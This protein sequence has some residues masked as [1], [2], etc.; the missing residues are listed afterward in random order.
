MATP[1]RKQVIRQRD[2]SA[3][4]I[5]EDAERR[6]DTKIFK[7]AL[8]SASNVRPLPTGALTRRPGRTILYF[9]GGLHDIVR[10]A[11]DAQFDVTFAA[12]RFTARTTTGAI[13]SDLVAPWTADILAEM[14]WEPIG[15]QIFV[16]HRDMVPQVLTYDRDAG[17]W[18]IADYDFATGLSG[19][20]KAAFYRFGDAG[21]T[22]QPSALSGT[23]TLTASA[24]IFKAGHVGVLFRYGVAPGLSAGRQMRITAV[25]ANGLTATATVIETLPA[26]W[27]VTL[28]AVAGFRVGEIVEGDT[29]GAY[30]QVIAVNTGSTYLDVLMVKGFSGFADD[31]TLVGAQGGSTVTSSTT[32][33][34]SFAASTLWDEQFMSDH[35][36]WPGSVSSDNNRVIFCDFGQLENAIIWG[37]INAPTDLEVTGDADAAIFEIAPDVCRVLYVAAG[38]DEFVLT[39]RRIYYIPI[40]ASTPL[41][42]GSVDFRRIGTGG[43]ARVKPLAVADGLIFVGQAKSRLYAILATGQVTR[44]YEIAPINEFHEHL[45]TDPIGLAA[46]DGDQSANPGKGLYVVNSDGSLILGHGGPRD[47]FVG[48]FP[49]PGEGNILSVASRD[50]DVRFSVRYDL[51]SGS[52]ETVESIDNGTYFDGSVA[53]DD[54]A[55]TDPLRDSSGEALEDSTGEELYAES[56]ALLPFANETLQGYANGFY[57][58]DVIIDETGRVAIEGNADLTGVVIGWNFTP[59][60]VPFLEDFEGGD[61]MGQRLRRRKVARAAI[62][63]K[64]TQAFDV[65]GRTYNSYL[66]GEDWGAVPPARSG[67]HRLRQTGRSDDPGFTITQPIPGSF[68]LQEITTQITV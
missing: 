19:T 66:M 38:G 54:F 17:T 33:G 7:A 55:G 16:A 5:D 15:K 50:G 60:I 40:S 1:I 24:A 68:T 46:S 61:D 31:E 42:P 28:A 8:R 56:G 13:V 32:T 49:W 21:V 63:V 48:W 27:R 67:V 30:G 6:D 64:D 41:V 29:S 52:V 14:V 9:D 25:A 43:A 53:L 12:G 57:L 22:I 59:E 4:E 62:K 3:G 20:V 44:P 39:D 18:S 23:I 47:D 45:F 58:G 34:P 35:R 11:S 2:F 65:D 26:T 10:P 51:N 36:G 37:S